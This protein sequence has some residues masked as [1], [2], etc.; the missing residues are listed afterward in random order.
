MTVIDTTAITHL[1]ARNLSEN[2]SVYFI[3]AF[4][5]TGKLVKTYGPMTYDR[6]KSCMDA[7]TT[8]KP[9]IIADWTFAL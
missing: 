7:A 9:K 1:N 5:S 6:A 3:D 8:A 4:H 2:G